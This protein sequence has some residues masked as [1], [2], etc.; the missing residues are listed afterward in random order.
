MQTFLM[1]H[2]IE[3]RDY[4]REIGRWSELAAIVATDA[5][6]EEQA[7]INILL[8]RSSLDG[9]RPILRVRAGVFACQI[10]SRM[11]AGSSQQLTQAFATPAA[12]TRGAGERGK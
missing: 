1:R 3:E 5:E 7:A 11:V 8:G 12:I 10:Q 4:A 6:A 9:A 2:G